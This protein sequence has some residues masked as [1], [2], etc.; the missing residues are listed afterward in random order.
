MCRVGRG[1]YLQQFSSAVS[2][3]MHHTKSPPPHA[4]PQEEEEKSTDSPNPPLA[5][6]PQFHPQPSSPTYAYTLPK[7]L[8]GRCPVIHS[9]SLPPSLPPLLFS[10]PRSLP[11]GIGRQR[12]EAHVD[13]DAKV[14]RQ[15]GILHKRQLQAAAAVEEAVLLPQRAVE[16]VVAPVG[17]WWC[18]VCWGVWVCV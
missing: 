9:P 1:L 10:L 4:V 12:A 6:F 16:N 3:S 13:Q 17:K 15:P 8:V 5:S 18:G 7:F 2:F 11:L 14:V